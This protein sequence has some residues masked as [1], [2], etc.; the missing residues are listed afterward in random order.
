MSVLKDMDSHRNYHHIQR[1]RFFHNTFRPR[2]VQ[3]SEVKY[4]VVCKTSER[5]F[6]AGNSH[7]PQ[8]FKE[9]IKS[10]LVNSINELFAQSL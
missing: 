10:K 6:L 3:V 9:Y 5:F 2:F 8:R 4:L 7:I 1:L